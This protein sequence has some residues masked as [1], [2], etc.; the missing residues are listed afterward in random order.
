MKTDWNS[1]KNATNNST[2]EYKKILLRDVLESCTGYE[3]MMKMLPCMV[4][5]ETTFDNGEIDRESY[6][7]LGFGPTYIILGSKG[8]YY[9]EE[10]DWGDGKTEYDEY[11]LV[12][13]EDIDES[14]IYTQKPSKKQLQ[15]LKDNDEYIY[16]CLSSYELYNIMRK[17]TEKQSDYIS[18]ICD[19]LK[20]ENPNIK[21]KTEAQKWISEH[22]EEYN[23]VKKQ[24]HNY[25][26]SGDDWDEFE[27]GCYSGP[28]PWGE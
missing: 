12:N 28:G 3:D 9:E 20:I 18:H 17:I 1:Y 5:I 6:Y 24:N 16:D 4:C 19:C 23:K 27:A 11:L 2:D 8:F 7:L 10:P 13:Y 22:I 15:W 14:Y 25:Y 26:D 21:T